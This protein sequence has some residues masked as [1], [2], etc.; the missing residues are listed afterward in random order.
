MVFFTGNYVFLGTHN[1]PWFY[2]GRPASAILI[3]SYIISKINSK[4][5]IAFILS[6]MVFA[7]LLAIKDSYGK[8]QV[9]LEPDSSSLMSNQLAAIDY[10]YSQPS[11]FEINTLTNPLY[12]NAVWSYQYYWYGKE[13]YGFLPTWIGGSQLYPYNTLPN[14][15]GHEKYLYLLMDTT[16]RIP[17]QYINETVNSANKISTLIEEKQFG[18][19][20]VQK[21]LLR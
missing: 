15:N 14:T 4:K 17:I 18:G 6:L 5:V 20:K 8:A 13:K 16:S 11:T 7:N 2:I 19:I 12:I 21:R 1:A 10:T 3:G 9:L